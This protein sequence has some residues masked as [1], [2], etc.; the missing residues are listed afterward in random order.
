M[1]INITNRGVL[2][3]D[4]ARIVYRNFSGVGSQFNR[5]G[6]RNFCLIIPN[7]EIA[8]M[9]ISQGWNVKIK[10]PR[11][12]GDEPFMFLPVKI[13]FNDRGPSVYLKSG[14]RQNRLNEET[15]GMLDNIDIRSV[16]MDIRP[17]DWVMY[18][19]TKNE[20]SGRTAYLQSI[21]VEQEIDRFTARYT[22]DEYAQE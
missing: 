15:V 7:Q 18:E 1:N 3:I 5:E 14:N 11:E 8:D 4:D 16:D 22:E 12:E 17:Y 21:L 9:L 13:K 10:A 19:G 6:D 20:R 2:Q